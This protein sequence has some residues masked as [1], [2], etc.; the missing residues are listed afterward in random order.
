MCKN[1]FFGVP[2]TTAT[3]VS[4]IVTRVG[5]VRDTKAVKREGVR[6]MRETY[7]EIPIK[8]DG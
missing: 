8:S 5:G 3:L 6:F 7:T 1:T 4:I 2:L